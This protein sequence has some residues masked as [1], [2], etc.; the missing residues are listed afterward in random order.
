[1]D[2]AT[3]VA[4]A[5]AGGR[6]V[7]DVR[8][9]VAGEEMERDDA[10][11]AIVAGDATVRHWSERWRFERDSSMDSSQTDLEHTLK[12]GDEGWMVA[13]RG[14]VVTQIERLPASAAAPS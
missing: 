4:A 14:W 12:F 3:I 10:T 8:L 9:D 5:V 13:H 11:A 7:I 6:E 1:M 2:D